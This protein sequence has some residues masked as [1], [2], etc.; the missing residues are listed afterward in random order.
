MVGSNRIGYFFATWWTM[1]WISIGRYV[2]ILCLR[3]S[4]IKLP[5]VKQTYG[6]QK[7]KCSDNHIAL[8]CQKR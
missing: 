1:D 5:Q 2:H 6:K 8:L 7:K 4:R 3:V